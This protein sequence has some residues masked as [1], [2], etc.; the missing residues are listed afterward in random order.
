MLRKFLKSKLLKSAGIYTITSGIN[1]AIPFL[2][3]PILTRYMSPDDYGIVSMFGVLVAFVAP[4]TGLS[5]HGAIQRQYYEKDSIDLPKYVGNCILILLLSSTIVALIFYLFA[6]PIS[7]VSSFPKQWLWI[8]IVVSIGQFLSQIVLT[9]WQVQLKAIKYGF[10]LILQTSL[11]AGLSVLLVVCVGM[12]WQGRIEAQ[13]IAFIIFGF[14]AFWILKN[15][16]LLKFTIEWKYI[17]NALNFGV[18][19]IPHALGGVIITIT[20]RL[21]IT[22]MI[23][24]DATGLYTVGYQV[25]MIIGLLENAFNQAYVPWLFERLK[26]NNEVVKAKIVKITYIYFLIII[27]LALGLGLISTWFLDFFVGKRFVGSSEFV[28]WIALGYVF[29]GMYKMVVGYIFY[30]EKTH[31]LSWI[32]FICAGI[33]VVLNYFFIK[34]NGAVGAAQASTLTFFLS[35]ILTWVLSYRVYK[36]P[37]FSFCSYSGEDN[38]SE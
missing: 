37:W 6:E 24:L 27:S 7:R 38:E 2:L 30:M 33:N 34:I 3:M 36:M 29:N 20:D 25:G 31:I 5:I 32:T 21:F 1:S 19:L 4:F 16:K 22:N 9:L 26:L 10:F 8:V 23:G 28:I 18:P 14:I 17:R 12:A 35:F 11:N 15:N 13:A